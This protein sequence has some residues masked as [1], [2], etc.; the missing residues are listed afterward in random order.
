MINI[1]CLLTFI[2]LTD[3]R[4]GKTRANNQEAMGGSTEAR[5]GSK[6]RV[7]KNQC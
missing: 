2:L 5:E 7:E 1:D 3:E 6:R 4:T